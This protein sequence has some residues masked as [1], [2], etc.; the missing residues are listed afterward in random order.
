[1]SKIFTEAAL[2]RYSLPELRSLFH[3]AQLDLAASDAGT[4]ERR[5][6]QASL[7]TISRVIAKRTAPAPRL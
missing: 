7:N 1:M 3:Q 4:S 6:A 2:N 5:D